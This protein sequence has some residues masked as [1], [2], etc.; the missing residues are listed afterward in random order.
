MN[1]APAASEDGRAR[2]LRPDRLGFA[3]A[4]AAL[5]STLALVLH[6]LALQT[7]AA[8][9]A[10][11]GIG[12]L[13]LL[14]TPLLPWLA[15][16]GPK[17]ANGPKLLVFGAAS[18]LVLVD[19]I[20]RPWFADPGPA[21][22]V[23]VA[24]I[25]AIAG[26]AIAP[27]LTTADG[28]RAS[29]V[30]VRW[31]AGGLTMLCVTLLGAA[32]AAAAL[33]AHPAGGAPRAYRFVSVVLLTIFAY[34]LQTRFVVSSRAVAFAFGL[35]FLAG[36]VERNAG[37]ATREGDWIRALDG[38]AGPAGLAL[39]L[40]A[41]YCTSHVVRS[42]TLLWTALAALLAAGAIRSEGRL[43]QGTLVGL[44]VFLV[45]AVLARRFAGAAWT[46]LVVLAALAGAPEAARSRFLD[47][48]VDSLTAAATGAGPLR[49]GLALAGAAGLARARAS[50]AAWA[51]FAASVTWGLSAPHG[52]SRDSPV[53]LVS[54]IGFCLLTGA[55]VDRRVAAPSAENGG[56]T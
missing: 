41:L 8:A 40:G 2:G 51:L 14:C 24:L 38:P 22:L 35:A 5:V 23:T 19:W 12:S 25:L 3:C 13:A 18:V 42:A 49:I 43:L 30:E 26:N 46:G 6:G 55:L 34:F 56:S 16:A 45:H 10:T 52:V 37:A 17:P 4:V 54:A 21:R 39:S 53:A 33:S 32:L 11:R 44:C 15:L 28:A 27:F 20:P 7:H 48:G 9:A 29:R 1:G 36:A 47:I 31:G 50:E